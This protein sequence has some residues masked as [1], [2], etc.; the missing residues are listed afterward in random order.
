MPTSPIAPTSP[1]LPAS[2]ILPSSQDLPDGAVDQQASRRM[3]AAVVPATFVVLW[4]SG[5]VVARLV[6]PFATPESFVSLRFVLSAAILASLAGI[7][8][9]RWPRSGRVWGECLAAGALM[10]GIYVGGIFWAVRHGLPAALA[11][12]ISGLQ[13]LL[14]GVLA[15]PLLGERVGPR[16]WFGI[17]VGFIGVAL[18]LA[19]KLHGTG[20]IAPAAVMAG[21]IAMIGITLGTIWQKRIGAS[22]DLR[23]AAAIQFLGGLAVTLPP[24]LLLE[25]DRF[26]PNAH[27]FFGLGWSVLVLSVGT[28]LLLLHLIKGGAVARVTSLFYLVPPLTAAFAALLF[29]DRLLPLQMV[30][31]GVAAAGV[32]FARR[33]G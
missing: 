8:K 22:L 9:A 33:E 27:L 14:T 28:A 6:S 19:P 7:G 3:L 29:A 10:Q 4:S 17:A 20:A 21:L 24:A 12:L 25:R 1:T 16:R 11:A 2:P 5:F 18:V 32:A 13:P 31:M 15:G 30:G 26:T 23:S